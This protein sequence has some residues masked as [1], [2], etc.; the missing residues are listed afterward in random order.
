[1]D[2]VSKR[3]PKDSYSIISPAFPEWGIA[4]KPQPAY[5]AFWLWNRYGG[6]RVVDEYIQPLLKVFV[7]RFDTTGEIGVIAVNW[8]WNQ[9]AVLNLQSNW[10]SSFPGTSP[11]TRPATQ[12]TYKGVGAA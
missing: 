9:E 11:E 2:G 4:S 10:F 8:D 12:A 7:T 3:A 5:Y 6:D 1:M